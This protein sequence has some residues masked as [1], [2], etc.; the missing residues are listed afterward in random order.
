MA[1]STMTS[2]PGAEGGAPATQDAHGQGI[3]TSVRHRVDIASM[4][5]YDIA[6]LA[7]R[8]AGLPLSL[9]LWQQNIKQESQLTFLKHAI[10]A[11]SQ[12]VSFC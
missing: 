5:W 10:V 11:H 3:A 8:V 12:Y 9:Y 6:S 2:I 7:I 1:V 4:H